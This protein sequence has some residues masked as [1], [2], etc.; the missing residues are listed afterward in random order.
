MT[1]QPSVMLTGKSVRLR[2][3]R[4]SDIERM[5]DIHVD[6]A[7]RGEF[8]PLDVTSEPAFRREFQESG[9]W[10]K[11]SGLLL[12]VD[13]TGQLLGDIGFFR[14]VPQYF[15][16]LEIYYRVYDH[17]QRGKGVT[18]EALNLLVGYLF[19][20]RRVNRIQL[21]IDTENLASRR[22]A[23]K[24]GFTHE[25]TARKAQ[26]L[27]GEHHDIEIYSILRDEAAKRRK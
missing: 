14:P 2:P 12:I 9:F 22:V 24:C 19:D 5:Y 11:D 10:T 26:F 4:E 21:G 13:D 25:G 17:A 27:R 15:D 16:A 7:N 20:A 3:V 23:E 6:I 8:W 1:N 18:S